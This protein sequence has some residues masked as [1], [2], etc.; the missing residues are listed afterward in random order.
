MANSERLAG[1]MEVRGAAFLSGQTFLRLFVQYHSH[2]SG[3]APYTTGF[4]RGDGCGGRLDLG[5]VEAVQR[6]DLGWRDLFNRLCG[7]G[8][9]PDAYGNDHG[10]E[11]GLSSVGGILPSS[12]A[13]LELVEGPAANRGVGRF[14]RSCGSVWDADDGAQPGLARQP[15]S[16]FRR[17]TRLTRQRKDAQ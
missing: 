4:A 6:A 2:I 11:V 8:E 3:L 17:R 14:D 9:H 13:G 12:G 7:H 5:S 15:E 10:R 16:L 1:S